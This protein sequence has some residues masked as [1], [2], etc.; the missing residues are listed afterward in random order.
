MPFKPP[1][2]RRY[3]VIQWGIGN[4]GTTAVE[5]GTAKRDIPYEGG[6]TS[7]MPGLKG[8]IKRGTVA[9]QHH[10]WTTWVDNKPFI[11]FHE[12]YTMDQFDAIE[13]QPDWGG[14]YHYRI[15][16]EG[17]EPTELILQAPP[18]PQG[19]YKKPGYTWTAMGPANTIPAVCDAP[20]GFITHVELGLMQLRG[21]VRS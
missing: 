16:I 19:S 21:V 3:R 17:D 12:M 14:H 2:D 18:D 5:L 20:P 10:T 15:V 4:V 1:P 8:V 9:S 11:T 7:D 13:P 6:E